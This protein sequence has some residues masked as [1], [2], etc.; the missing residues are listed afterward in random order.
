[1]ILMI[2][3][4]FFMMDLGLGT[5]IALITLIAIVIFEYK[6]DRNNKVALFNTLLEELRH[7][8]NMSD[9]FV[10]EPSIDF[11]RTL[12]FELEKRYGK[13]PKNILEKIKNKLNKFLEVF[14]R[15]GVKDTLLNDSKEFVRKIESWSEYYESDKIYLNPSEDPTMPTIGKEATIFFKYFIPNRLQNIEPG[16]III[17]YQ[18]CAIEQAIS[19]GKIW[20]LI[21]KRP[22]KNLGHLYYSYRRMDL[23]KKRYAESKL[24]SNWHKEWCHALGLNKQMP[25]HQLIYEYWMWVHFRLWF[26]YLDLLLSSKKKLVHHYYLNNLK[27][28]F[29]EKEWK[30]LRN[31]LR[32]TVNK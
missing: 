13:K 15:N 1:M 10:I 2:N 26:L 3:I 32:K 18:T 11:I 31:N 16:E 22:A 21:G 29:E 28:M 4:F 30:R 27:S 8:I 17:D 25:H 19:S 20:T 5:I 9:A 24:P 6:K 14:R 12:C 7:N 23:H